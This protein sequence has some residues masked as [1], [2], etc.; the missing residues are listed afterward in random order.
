MT[1]KK[2]ITKEVTE[3]GYK[4]YLAAREELVNQ[5]NEI[6]KEKGQFPIYSFENYNTAGLDEE[7]YRLMGAI[8]MMND[9]ISRLIIVKHEH[10]TDG[11]I[12]WDDIVTVHF[13]GTDKIMRVQL[14]GEMASVLED[15]DL[16]KITRESP[17]GA[18]IFGKKVGDT[19]SYVIPSRTGRKSDQQS[20]TLKILA[21][22]NALENSQDENQPNN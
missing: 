11:R 2:V 21:K 7:A 22:E 6:N 5:L 12:G 15:E 13:V 20:L 3:E 18:A 14:T 1:T 9:E 4:Q 17:M 16:V 19:V 10:S 8:Q